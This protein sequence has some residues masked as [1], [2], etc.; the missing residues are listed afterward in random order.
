MYDNCDFILMQLEYYKFRIERKIIM[1]FKSNFKRAISILCV[2]AMIVTSVV[3]M[4]VSA[5]AETISTDENVFNNLES[6]NVW[7]TGLEKQPGQGFD[8]QTLGK[9]TTRHVQGIAGATSTNHKIYSR[10]EGVDS[11]GCVKFAS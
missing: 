1:S 6:Y 10:A 11:T 7:S 8:Y 4:S 2:I 9:N 3:V 5:S